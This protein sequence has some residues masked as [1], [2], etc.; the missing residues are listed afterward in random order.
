ANEDIPK[1]ERIGE[2]GMGAGETR[3]ARTDKE[4]PISGRVS[5]FPGSVS[6]DE[7]DAA[8]IGVYPF[9]QAEGHLTTSFTI[10]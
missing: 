6:P 10:R 5:S 9:E 7:T 1:Q 3:R 8:Q 4:E 2:A